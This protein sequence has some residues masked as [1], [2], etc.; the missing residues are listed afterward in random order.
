MARAPARHAERQRSAG[1]VLDAGA[2]QAL[3]RRHLRLLMDLREAHT[4]G[5]PIYVPAGALAQA[6]RGGPRSAALARLLK[7]PCSVVRV[8]EI[9][10]RQIGEFIACFGTGVSRPDIVDAQVALIGRAT[11]SLVWTSD[12]KDMLRYGVSS[13]HIRRL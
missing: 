13:S 10:A 2:L 1:L 9:S 6:W 8:D 5:A 12:P 3:E 11:G 4:L 7:Q